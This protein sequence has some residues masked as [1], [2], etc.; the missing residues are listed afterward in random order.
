M[1]LHVPRCWISGGRCSCRL[2]CNQGT[3][4]HSQHFQLFKKSNKDVLFFFFLLSL[5][6]HLFSLF[7]ESFFLVSSVKNVPRLNDVAQSQTSKICFLLTLSARCAHVNE[8]KTFTE[9]PVGLNISPSHTQKS[10]FFTF[11][12]FETLNWL[13][14]FPQ[15]NHSLRILDMK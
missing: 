1:W 9:P 12:F 6:F 2:K 15:F 11:F 3:H 7:Y 14:L 8:G 5:P 10:S 4:L 13:L